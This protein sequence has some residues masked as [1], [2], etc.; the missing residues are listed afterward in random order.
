MTRTPSLGAGT[1]AGIPVPGPARALLA[2]L[3]AAVLLA[4][5]GCGQRGPLYLPDQP[6][7][8][9]RLTGATSQPPAPAR[10]L[11]PD[12]VPARPLALSAPLLD[13]S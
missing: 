4:L 9:K 8:K 7:P 5:G 13:R 1:P 11:A 10:A 12:L 3:A 2:A 6:P